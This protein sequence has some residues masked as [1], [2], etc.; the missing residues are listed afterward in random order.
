MGAPGGARG[1][2]WSERAAGTA[3]IEAVVAGAASW[4]AARWTVVELAPPQAYGAIDAARRAGFTRV[5]TEGD[6]AGRLRMLVVSR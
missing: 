5:G 2:A 1:G 6:L 3:D 4:L